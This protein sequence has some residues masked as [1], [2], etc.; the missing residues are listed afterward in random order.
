M[1]GRP[2]FLRSAQV[3]GS[4]HN[5]K[6]LEPSSFFSR[7][8]SVQ[9]V[10]FS[11]DNN[12]ES[13]SSCHAASRDRLAQISPCFETECDGSV[14]FDGCADNFVRDSLVWLFKHCMA[15]RAMV[16]FYLA[17][18]GMKIPSRFDLN[19]DAAMPID[20]EVNNARKI[21]SQRFP[22]RMPFELGQGNVLC[23]VDDVRAVDFIRR[24][25]CFV[26]I[27]R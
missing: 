2:E 7:K 23:A 12:S 4:L 26:D 19:S 25:D 15:S 9:L 27:A 21:V 6:V 17:I 20:C 10:V 22:V 8:S 16:Q 5:A 24:F 11:L 13:V 1:D 14:F 18:R 3:G